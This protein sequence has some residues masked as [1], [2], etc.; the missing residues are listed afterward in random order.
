MS[1]RD[2]VAEIVNRY[3]DD[4]TILAW[5]LVNEPEVG[6]CSVV[7]EPTAHDLLKSFAADVSGLI[8]SIDP[9]HLVSL[10]T[11]GTGQCGAQGGDYEDVMS[12][13]TL[14]LCEYHD[15]QPGAMPGDQWN[16]LQV[17]LDQC[18]ALHKPLIVGEVGIRPSD[19]GGT[20][21]ARAST[22]DGQAG[23]PVPRRSGRR[24]RVGLEPERFDA[25]RLRHRAER[26][27]VAGARP[28]AAADRPAPA[29]RRGGQP[30]SDDPLDGAGG[31]RRLADHALRGDAVRRLHRP[32][33][34]DC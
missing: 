30:A 17:R 27:R 19:V 1:Y 33:A 32:R 8:K 9:H 11:L 18:N 13:P 12:V 16:G 15:Y 28:R 21:A 22:L 26:S 3:R 24:A 4:P 2:F 34:A 23:R 10:G 25:E 14:D 31:A 7:P 20:L 5:Q 29:E 6:D